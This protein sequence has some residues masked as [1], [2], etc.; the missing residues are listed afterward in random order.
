MKTL[1]KERDNQRQKHSFRFVYDTFLNG[2]ILSRHTSL[3][4]IGELPTKKR[5]PPFFSVHAVGPFENLKFKISELSLHIGNNLNI[6]SSSE[7]FYCDRHFF[8]FIQMYMYVTELLFY[9]NNNKRLE[10]N[11]TK[12]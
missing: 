5:T 2:F 3:E 6:S 11:R 4:L 10:C 1:I 12:L 7:S 8:I 9:R